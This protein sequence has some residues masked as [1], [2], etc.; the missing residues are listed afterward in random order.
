VDNAAV[1]LALAL[2]LVA[3]PIYALLAT[4]Q[5]AVRSFWSF[6]ALVPLLR[7]SAF[8]RG[9][10]TLELLLVLFAITAAIAVE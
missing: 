1:R 7:T 8:G 3:V 9:Y 6:G 5:F 2:A 4:S 10:L